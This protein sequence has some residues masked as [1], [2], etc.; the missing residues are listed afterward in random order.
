[1][2]YNRFSAARQDVFD[3]PLRA[4]IPVRRITIRTADLALLV[5][6]G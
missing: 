3:K 4:K 2:Q 6:E 5:L 1:M